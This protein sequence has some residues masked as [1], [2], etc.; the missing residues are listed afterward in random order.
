MDILNIP[1]RDKYNGAR[2]TQTSLQGNGNFGQGTG[3]VSFT[4]GDSS[5]CD[6]VSTV[7]SGSVVTTPTPKY[8]SQDDVDPHPLHNADT[9]RFNDNPWHK[10]HFHND[11]ST[12][13]NNVDRNDIKLNKR[14][15]SDDEESEEISLRGSEDKSLTTTTR[16][17]P[18]S[19]YSLAQFSDI[20]FRD[21]RRGS[22]DTGEGLG[23]QP[24]QKW[25][26]LIGCAIVQFFSALMVSLQAPF[27]PAEV[28][29][30]K[31]MYQLI[32]QKFMHWI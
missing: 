4:I 3:R 13:H 9:N 31:Y 6:S 26:I 5:D 22:N 11:L 32:L 30:S 18:N 2:N 29:L 23:S 10:F 19:N 17:A 21:G 15:D 7:T 27:Y 16:L 8:D 20:D 14:D 28:C 24:W 12:D 1:Q 25:R